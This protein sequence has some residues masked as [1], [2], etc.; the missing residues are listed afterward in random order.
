MDANL[1]ENEARS[2]VL[3]DGVEGT[4]YVVA[5]LYY[6]SAGVHVAVPYVSDPSVGQFST[7]DEWFG[8]FGDSAVPVNLRYQDTELHASFFGTQYRG[9]NSNLFEGTSVGRFS[10]DSTVVGRATGPIDEPLLVTEMQSRVDGLYEWTQ[11][12]AADVKPEHDQHGRVTR[13]EI[14][15]ESTQK[16]SWKHGA[17]TV[18]LGTD[19]A[20]LESGKALFDEWVTLS[21]RFDSPA[22]VSDH[23]AVQ[24]SIRTLLAILFGSAIYFRRHVVASPQFQRVLPESA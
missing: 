1:S 4:P 23:I 7:V 14:T 3:V 10:V 22:P 19:W 6:D 16:L 18:E 8:R 12:R 15:V 2:G 5:T 9:G 17:A 13:L 20:G 24:A 21:T 11:F